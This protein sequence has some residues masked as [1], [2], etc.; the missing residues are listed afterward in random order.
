MKEGPQRKGERFMKKPAKYLLLLGILFHPA[1]PS[2]QSI[3]DE[4][5]KTDLVS[6]VQGNTGFALDLYRKLIQAPLMENGS[7]NLFLSPYSISTAMA[8][9]WAGARG[10]TEAQMAKVLRFSLPQAREHGAFALLQDK[11]KLGG[12]TLNVANALWVQQG[13]ALLKSYLSLI[14]KHY[15]GGLTTLDFRGAL[16]EARQAIN[17]WVGEKTVQ[18]IEELLKPG[19]VDASTELVLTNA[20]YFKGR[21]ASRFEEKGTRTGSFRVLPDREVMVPMM[22]HHGSFGYAETDALQI[23]ELPYEGE[24]LSLV[25]LLPRVDLAE[26]ET[27]L[28]IKKLEAWLAAIRKE[29]VRIRLPRLKM[30]SHV[31]LQEILAAMGMPDAFSSGKADFSGMTGTRGFFIEKVIHEACVEVNEEGT[32]AAAATAVVAKR[33]GW[34]G[35][36]FFADHPFLFLIRDHQT[37]TILLMGRVM[38]PAE[39]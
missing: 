24:G 26:V 29:K 11:L 2:L 34:D 8:M 5:P 17:R 3:A 32:E 27:G 36:T 14:E 16:E 10:E 15:E 21:W 37:G 19:E 20:L 23:L 35:R 33:G 39:K 28:N 4:D 22:S 18:K 38:N 6:V 31:Q 25:V 1:F 7:G 13:V 12:C 9:T 30:T